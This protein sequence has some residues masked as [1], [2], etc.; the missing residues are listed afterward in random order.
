[1]KMIVKTI[2][3]FLVIIIFNIPIAYSIDLN[4]LRISA[5]SGDSKSCLLLGNCY[6]YGNNNCDKDYYSAFDWYYKSASLNNSAAQF[7]VALCYDQGIGVKKIN[8]R[9]WN[10]I[11]KLHEMEWFRQNLI[12]PYTIKMVLNLCLRVVL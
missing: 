8:I 7:N 1:M 10:G 4:D 9:H 3:T 6:F 2:I 5:M 11:E 12:W